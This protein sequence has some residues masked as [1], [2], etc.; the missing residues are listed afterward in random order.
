LADSGQRRGVTVCFDPSGGRA[1]DGLYLEGDTT[2]VASNRLKHVMRGAIAA[3]AVV[4]VV[5]LNSGAAVADPPNNLQDAKSQLDA[6]SKAAEVADQAYLAAKDD[7][8]AKQAEVAKATTDIQTY[9]QQAADAKTKES[10]YQGQVDQLASAAYSGAQ[11]TQLSALLTGKSAQDFLDQSSELQFLA[12][13]NAVVMDGY[14]NAIK[15]ANSARTKAAD[16]QKRSQ[17]AADAAQKILGELDQKKQDADTAK[18]KAQSAYNQLDAAAKGL[19]K[20]AGDMGVF[21][22]PATAA[23]KAME[24]AVGERGVAYV[25]G[26]TTPAGFDCSGLTQWAYRQA[27]VT[28]PR[29]AAAQFTVGKAVSLNS[30]A[31]G[32]L[33]FYGSTASNIHHVSMYVGDGKVVHAPTEGEVVKVVPIGNSGSDIF[34]AKRIVG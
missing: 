19:L 10:Q 17:T 20:G 21:L 33:I 16:A 7:L 9:T 18:D 26:G 14:D 12:Q 15:T 31:I 8:A 29:S 25:W 32:D 28:I 22:G 5:G 4:T 13:Q 6:A 3:S 11:F 23:G 24:A 1:L 2:D 27:G 30:L 34:G